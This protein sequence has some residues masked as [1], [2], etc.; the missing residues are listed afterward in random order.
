MNIS[1]NDIKA[2]GVFCGS[3]MGNKEVYQQAAKRMGLLMASQGI[4]LVY[5]GGNVGLMGVIADAILE[6][7]G[8]VTGVITQHLADVELAHQGAQEMIIVE[9]MSERKNK[10]VALSDAFI[11]MPGGLGTFDELF[12]A[13]TLCQLHLMKKPIGLLNTAHYFEALM[14]MVDHSIAEGFMREEHRDFFV[15]DMDERLLLEKLRRHQPPES[16]KWLENFN[17]DKH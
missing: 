5:G 8:H 10:I 14:H 11:A 2:I 9:S 7:G 3:A 4:R 16:R 6:A 17:K 1:Q 15:E 13:L 12:E